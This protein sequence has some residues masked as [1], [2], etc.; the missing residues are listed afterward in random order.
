MSELHSRGLYKRLRGLVQLDAGKT[1]LPM[2]SL[3]PFAFPYHQLQA[4]LPEVDGDLVSALGALWRKKQM[5][6]WLDSAFKREWDVFLVPE[7]RFFYPY[8]HGLSPPAKL[9]QVCMV[10]SDREYLAAVIA[11]GDLEKTSFYLRPRFSSFWLSMVPQNEALPYSTV[12]DRMQRA[13]TVLAH[14][15]D[16]AS[17]ANSG[18]VELP[19]SGTHH[20]TSNARTKG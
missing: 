9:T 3:T 1:K 18:V 4:D 13:M 6:R 19:L 2:Q 10:L 5:P 20:P 15:I 12:W 14:L 16:Q 7:V 11:D 8:R 17:S